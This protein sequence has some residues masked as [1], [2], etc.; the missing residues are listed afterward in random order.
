MYKRKKIQRYKH[1]NVQKCRN[2][3]SNVKTKKQ[4]YKQINVQTLK[5]AYKRTK[6]KQTNKHINV[7]K[8]NL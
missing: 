3:Q 5:Q 2:L 1:I 6:N 7:S 8:T 4:A